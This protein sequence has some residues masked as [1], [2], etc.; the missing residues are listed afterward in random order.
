MFK[1]M[2]LLPTAHFLKYYGEPY[3]NKVILTHL[4]KDVTKENLL[5]DSRL[6]EARRC[7]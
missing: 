6:G 2:F 5:V 4:K 3:W 1:D 7:N